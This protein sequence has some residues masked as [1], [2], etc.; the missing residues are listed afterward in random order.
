M[1]LT[2]PDAFQRILV[3]RTDRIGDLVLTTPVFE[4]LR[5]KFPDA[6]LACLAF[7]ENREIVEGNPYLD[8]VILYD[9]KGSERGWLGNFIFARRL[10]RKR[11]DVVIH[12][13]PTNRMHGVSWLAG[14]PI[15]I[16][17]RKKNAWTLT[18][19][20]EDRKSEGLKHESEY[21]FDLLKLMGIEP[22]EKMKPYFP[23]KEKDKIS[24]DFFLRNLGLNGKT[25]AVLNP[26]ASCPSKIWHAERFARLADRLQE[27]LG[28]RILLIG[29]QRDKPLSEKLRRY[30]A[31]PVIDLTGKLS[32]GM[33]GWLLKGS[34]ILVSN[35]SG[36]VHIAAAVG[37]PTVSIFGRKQAGLSPRRWGPLGENT[38]VIHKEVACSVCLAHDCRINFLCL[39]VISVE[40]VFQ[41]AMQML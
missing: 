20:M 22:P 1:T 37:T 13:H 33:L 9:K 7:L 15:R 16:G 25:Y 12:L 36:P 28:L 3:T 10:A 31:Q 2:Q 30:A 18:H 38:K 23:L 19:S 29:S 39:D 32:L 11:F 21:N 40:E 8:E 41:E 34:S 35:D 14:I 4:A 27:K 6:H 5:K 17:Y 24:L 26:S